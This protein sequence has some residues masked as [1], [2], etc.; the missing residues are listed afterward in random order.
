MDNLILTLAIAFVLIV[1]ALAFFGIGWLI[2]GKSKIKPGACG[3][4]PT[5][6]RGKDCGD[7]SSCDLCKKPDN[8][9]RQ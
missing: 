1:A 4:T 5:E 9:D 6:N 2:T 3:R 8:E 7:Q